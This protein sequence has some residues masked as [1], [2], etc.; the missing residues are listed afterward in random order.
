[1]HIYLAKALQYERVNTYTLTLQ[2]RNSPDLVAEALLTIDVLDENNQAPVFTNVESGNVLEH[3]P[4]GT[5]VMQVSAIDNDGTSPNNRVTYDI[6]ASNPSDVRSKFAI[7][8]NTGVVT[9]RVEFDREEQSVYALTIDAIDG[10]PSSLLRNG[11][12]N[13][14]PQ[15]FRVAIAD[16]NDNPPYFPQQ[17]YKAEVPEDQDVGSKVGDE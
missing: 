9:T 4:A 2:V 1:M 15:K 6:S 7:D 11:R 16:K 12:P 5:I 10:A 8:A 14:T 17:L 13:V 3:E